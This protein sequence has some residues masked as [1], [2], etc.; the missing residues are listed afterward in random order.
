ML[1][2]RFLEFWVGAGR[3]KGKSKVNI[4]R[5][6][7]DLLEW[8][9][10]RSD[11][12][13]ETSRDDSRSIPS[14]LPFL[15]SWDAIA[16]AETVQWRGERRDLPVRLFNI[17]RAFRI[18]C[19]KSIVW[20]ASNHRSLH[21]LSSLRSRTVAASLECFLQ[22]TAEMHS[23]GSRTQYPNKIC[24]YFDDRVG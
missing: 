6:S 21:F 2:S 4:Q 3:K 10:Q 19:E 7:L 22:A 1:F 18:E 12:S 20:T 5:C 16:L 9:F 8:P 11:T 14:Y 24:S 15:I 13:C 23:T 17:F